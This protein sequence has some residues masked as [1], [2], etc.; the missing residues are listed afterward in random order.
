VKGSWK[1]SLFRTR[2]LDNWSSAEWEYHGRRSALAE[3]PEISKLEM[4]KARVSWVLG[5]AEITILTWH[6]TKFSSSRSYTYEH[7]VQSVSVRKVTVY[8]VVKT[9][10]YSST[11]F[12]IYSYLLYIA[13]TI[14][15]KFKKFRSSAKFSTG[16]AKAPLGLVRG[17]RL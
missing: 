14:V 17:V 15:L 1:V 10:G 4:L 9:N 5:T 8:G 13:S 11:K 2:Y 7:V 6:A 16:S 12:S 3:W